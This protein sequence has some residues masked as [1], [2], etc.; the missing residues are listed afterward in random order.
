M[1]TI[2]TSSEFLTQEEH[3]AS[4]EYTVTAKD[5][6]CKVVFSDTMDNGS[7][8]AI[9]PGE[10]VYIIYTD[11]DGAIAGYVKRVLEYF[12]N[13]DQTKILR[14]KLEFKIFVPETVEEKPQ[15][16]IAPGLQISNI[17]RHKDMLAIIFGGDARS[18]FSDETLTR[19]EFTEKYSMISYLGKMYH[20]V[21]T[22]DKNGGISTILAQF[23]Y[24]QVVSDTGSGTL[25]L[26]CGMVA[27]Y[28]CNEVYSEE[29]YQELKKAVLQ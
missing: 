9:M 16:T 1:I 25:Y 14:L 15:Y 19:Q 28:T 23:Q 22:L 3:Q 12:C 18:I 11:T 10:L 26:N 4:T 20:V 7:V 5:Q 21:K 13:K 8:R 17:I 29:T 6:D 2:K 27:Y 24:K